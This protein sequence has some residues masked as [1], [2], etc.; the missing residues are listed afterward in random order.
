MDETKRPNASCYSCHSFSYIILSSGYECNL[1]ITFFGEIFTFLYFSVVISGSNGVL[2]ACLSV[3]SLF[4]IKRRNEAK[5]YANE[6]QNFRFFLWSAV[7]W[8]TYFGWY[9]FTDINT[10]QMWGTNTKGQS[11][12]NQCYEWLSFRCLSSV[13][14]RV[15]QITDPMVVFLRWYSWN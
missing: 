4:A 2:N 3:C 9:L 14:K 1:F 13:W 12:S 8:N 7:Q 10:E 6:W 11:F 5:N 15:Q